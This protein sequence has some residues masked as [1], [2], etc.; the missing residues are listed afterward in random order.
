MRIQKL[1]SD[2]KNEEIV[3][4]D[5]EKL[6]LNEHEDEVKTVLDVSDLPKLDFEVIPEN[7]DENPKPTIVP[8]FEGIVSENKESIKETKNLMDS[9]SNIGD[10]P[11]LDL[12]EKKS[13][14]VDFKKIKLKKK[15]TSQQPIILDQKKVVNSDTIVVFGI[16]FATVDDDLMVKLREKEFLS[17][18]GEND[19]LTSLYLSDLEEM[20]L[21]LIQSKFD[22]TSSVSML[23]KMRDA[24]VESFS[25]DLIEDLD[26]GFID[27]LKSQIITIGKIYLE[28]NNDVVLTIQNPELANPHPKFSDWIRAF[29]KFNPNFNKS[30]KVKDF[31]K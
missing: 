19:Y 3:F 29:I 24:C 13:K 16:P 22:P 20:E 5:D 10:L 7:I 26:K 2:L 6:Q 11:P 30:S 23:Y 27:K 12:P 15:E 21:S 17:S 25:Y 8:E 18:T 14:G 4:E 1:Q 31:F 9:L 28:S